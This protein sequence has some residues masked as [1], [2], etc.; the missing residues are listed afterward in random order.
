MWTTYSSQDIFSLNYLALAQNRSQNE[1]TRTRTRTRTRI[2]RWIHVTTITNAV[3]YNNPWL[4]SSGTGNTDVIPSSGLQSLSN[5]DY[6]TDLEL[7]FIL[8]DL[9][10]NEE[11]RWYITGADLALAFN[12]EVSTTTTSTIS[13]YQ[14]KYNEADSYQTA[15][16]TIAQKNI[17]IKWSFA[18]TD[19]YLLSPGFMLHRGAST[20]GNDLHETFKSIFTSSDV[21]VNNIANW[22][23]SGSGIYNH[24]QLVNF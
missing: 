10:N 23:Q 8:Y 9:S 7:L 4:G 12:H 13:S 16:V 1:R 19:D 17:N 15:N 22:T 5:N 21:P 2:I 14:Y 11:A 24:G 18:N 20:G 6:G 3:S